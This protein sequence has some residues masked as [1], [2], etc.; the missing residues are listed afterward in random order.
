MIPVEKVYRFEPPKEE[1]KYR[2]ELTLEEA[3][4]IMRKK[5]KVPGMI[6]R[7]EEA[8]I[9]EKRKKLEEKMSSGLYT[10]GHSNIYASRGG[11][12]AD[13]DFED[14]FADDEEGDIFEEKTRTRSYRR[15]RSRKI[16]SKP[17]SWISRTPETWTYSS[18]LRKRKKRP[19]RRIS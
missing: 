14:D 11:E 1:I 4:Q 2:N 9:Q 18:N 3:E 13:L 15:R 12:D 6:A 10:G 5:K 8:M 16:S 17:I 19:E 7:H